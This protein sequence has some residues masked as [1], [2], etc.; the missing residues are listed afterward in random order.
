MVPEALRAIGEKVELKTDHFDEDTADATWV[1]EVGARGWI[2]LSADRQ[3]RH[4]H[5]EIVALL[6]SNTHSFLLTSGNLTGR[7]M[8]HAFVTAMPDI[9]GVISTIPPPAV[10]IVSKPGRVRVAYT[11]DGLIER[12]IQTSE[13]DASSAKKPSQRSRR[14]KD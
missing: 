11:H 9:K 12:V 14:P 2:I 3:L 5:I 6:K 7:E 13:G 4:N 1:T 8:A 10:C